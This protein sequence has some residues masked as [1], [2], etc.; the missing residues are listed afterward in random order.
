MVFSGVNP[1][2]PC[3]LRFASARARTAANSMFASNF[4]FLF[5]SR[6]VKG[7]I[8]LALGIKFA[9]KLRVSFNFSTRLRVRGYLVFK[10]YNCFARKEA[11]F[12]FE[13]VTERFVDELVV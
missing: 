8:K 1:I 7:K 6:T 10:I 13:K 4:S 5:L 11:K 12:L 9:S 2:I 3:F